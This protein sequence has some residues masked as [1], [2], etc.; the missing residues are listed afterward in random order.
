MD[1]HELLDGYSRVWDVDAPAGLFDELF[2]EDVTDHNPVPG[3]GPGRDGM[4]GVVTLY[5]AVFP[6]LHLTTEDILVDG[7]RGTLRWTATGTH[8]GDQL[9]MPATGRQVR[10]TG[11]DVVR[12]ADGRIVERWGES[13]GLEMMQQLTGEDTGAAPEAA[14]A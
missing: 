10:L 7:E 3:Q 12:A 13:N 14:P 8:R 9:G 5:H 4:R 6:D 2:A 11:I 1:L